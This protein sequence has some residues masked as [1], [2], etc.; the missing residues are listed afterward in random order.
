MIGCNYFETPRQTEPNR[1]PPSSSK[2]VTNSYNK[3]QLKTK[4]KLLLLRLRGCEF[5]E[6]VAYNSDNKSDDKKTV[7]KGTRTEDST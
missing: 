5:M 3:Y 7:A 2:S 1:S 6:D 4:E